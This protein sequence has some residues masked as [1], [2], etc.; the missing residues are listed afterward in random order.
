[1]DPQERLGGCLWLIIIPITGYLLCS[2]FSWSF[3]YDNW[4]TVSHIVKWIFLLLEGIVISDVIDRWY[5]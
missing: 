3:V 1:M 5:N 4:N 2:L